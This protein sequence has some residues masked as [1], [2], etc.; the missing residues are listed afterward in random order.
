MLRGIGELEV[1]QPFE[2]ACIQ[3][4]AFQIQPMVITILRTARRLVADEGP[5]KRG[6]S[7][8]LGEAVVPA[9]PHVRSTRR[10]IWVFTQRHPMGDE[11]HALPCGV[12]PKAS[13]RSV[14]HMKHHGP[15][16]SAAPA[17]DDLAYGWQQIA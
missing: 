12:C 6:V 14:F 4:A 5:H 7:R 3:F 17:P 16:F 15:Y 13:V 2:A 9:G 11:R 1:P 10:L 8:R